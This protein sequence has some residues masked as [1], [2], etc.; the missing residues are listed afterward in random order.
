MVHKLARFSCILWY[1]NLTSDDSDYSV[2]DGWWLGSDVLCV[3]GTSAGRCRWRRTYPRYPVFVRLATLHH[4]QT[5]QWV[6]SL[7]SMYYT[8]FT[9]SSRSLQFIVITGPKAYKLQCSMSQLSVSSLP[10]KK[11]GCYI[12]GLLVNLMWSSR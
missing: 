3:L 7:N 12:W 8:A 1:V 2:I 6:Q 10:Q 4:P 11:P 9:C 5:Q